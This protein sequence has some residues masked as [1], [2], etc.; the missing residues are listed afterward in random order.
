MHAAL[1]RIMQAQWH[2]RCQV[3]R[4]GEAHSKAAAGPPTAPPSAMPF[5][6]LTNGS[7]SSVS[8]RFMAVAQAA[9][10]AGGAERSSGALPHSQAW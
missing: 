7:V 6:R 10:S 3:L 4:A 1:L 8:T 5:T 2:L 9:S